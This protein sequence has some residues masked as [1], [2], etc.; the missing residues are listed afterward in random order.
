MLR[1]HTMSRFI[2]NF[3]VLYWVQIFIHYILLYVGK[4]ATL[5]RM[6]LSM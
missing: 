4:L 3:L 6:S 2:E 1:L 5:E